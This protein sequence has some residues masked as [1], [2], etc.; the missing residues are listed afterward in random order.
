MTFLCYLRILNNIRGKVMK[1]SNCGAPIGQDDKYC[2]YCGMKVE[3]PKQQNSQLNENA[4]GDEK[5]V[6]PLP[7]SKQT[8]SS[9]GN[10]LDGQNKTDQSYNAPVY[11]QKLEGLTQ[12]II[13]L[14][15][16]FII[17]LVTFICSGVGLSKAK[18]QI[19]VNNGVP[20]TAYVLNIVAMVF[21]CIMFVV[22]FIY[23]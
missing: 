19:E 6:S 15:F 2:S 7:L 17:P 22:N 13:G 9:F 21:A 12:A 23:Y 18:Q 10:F 8:P 14:I 16:A 5:T 1:C 3:S 20:K 4:S 11:G